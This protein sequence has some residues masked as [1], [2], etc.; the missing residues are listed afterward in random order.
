MSSLIFLVATNKL[1]SVEDS[2]SMQILAALRDLSSSATFIFSF[3]E[4][5]AVGSEFSIMRI[6]FSSRAEYR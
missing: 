2:S 5:V 6:S 3:P 4:R 1:V